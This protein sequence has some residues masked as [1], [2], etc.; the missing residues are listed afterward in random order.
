MWRRC[1]SVLAI[2]PGGKVGWA[3]IDVYRGE[4]PAPDD[5]RTHPCLGGYGITFRGIGTWRLSDHTIIG[6]LREALTA[7][8]ETH[9]TIPLCVIEHFTLTRT[10]TFSPTAAADTLSIF[11]MVKAM[12]V[13]DFRGMRLDTRQTPAEAKGLVS[14]EVL[15]EVGA[16]RRGDKRDDNALMAARH[17]VL[18]TA[19]LAKGTG[20]LSYNELWGWS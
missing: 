16:Y 1:V 15:R 10:G 18:L 19:R 9:E 6:D 5:V 3:I 4:G 2:D 17:A 20:D 11:G 14:L 7:V 8:Y 13:S 12:I